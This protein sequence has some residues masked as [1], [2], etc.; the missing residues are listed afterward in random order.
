MPRNRVEPTGYLTDVLARA[1]KHERSCFSACVRSTL[2]RRLPR[3]VDEPLTV[4]LS[5]LRQRRTPR[6]RLPREP[7]RFSMAFVVES[8]RS[9]HVVSCL[10]E[11]GRPGQGHLAADGARRFNGE[12]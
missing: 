12:S 2:E 7:M 5:T 3:R 11:C 8:V 6:P 4:W 1:R 10:D 9:S